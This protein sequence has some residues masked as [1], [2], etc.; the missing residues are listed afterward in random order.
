MITN[1][2][3]EVETH[4]SELGGVTVRAEL[5]IVATA[6]VHEQANK[7]VQD[8]LVEDTG[9]YLRHEIAQVIASIV[10]RGLNEI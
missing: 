10:E 8:L 4:E 9:L 2:T 1:K 6:N 5:K 3:F 7:K